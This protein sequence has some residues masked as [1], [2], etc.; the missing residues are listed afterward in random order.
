M[1][2][3]STPDLVFLKTA[4]DRSV[5]KFLMVTS[6]LTIGLCLKGVYNMANNV[7]KVKK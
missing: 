2:V 7:G 1:P 5:Y 4:Q 6:T 3:Q